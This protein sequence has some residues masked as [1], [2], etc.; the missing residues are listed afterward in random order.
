MPAIQSAPLTGLA[1]VISNILT[2]HPVQL[3]FVECCELSALWSQFDSG[4]MEPVEFRRNGATQI[5]A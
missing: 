3:D 2:K 5:P 1:V 4:I